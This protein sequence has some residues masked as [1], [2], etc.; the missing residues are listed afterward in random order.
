MK[1]E[2]PVTVSI[3]KEFIVQFS[4]KHTLTKDLIL[5]VPRGYTAIAYVDG[6]ALFKSTQCTNKVVIKQIGKEYLGKEIQFAFYSPHIRPEISYGFG[7][8]NVNNAR[9]KE[10]YR[11]GINGKMNLE[12]QDYIKLINQF[13]FTNNISVEMIRENILPLIKSVGIPI[14]SACFVD[15]MIS[16]FEIDSILGD[17]RDKMA[18]SFVKENALEALG[19]HVSSVSINQIH[20]NEE[21]LEMIRTRI[22]N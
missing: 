13:A 22:N 17:I 20:V 12:I 10:A 16:V 7:P 19:I 15:T 8:I 4:E 5:T 21:D 6:K 9:L 11:V 3:N 2:V 14:L 1:K 18:Q